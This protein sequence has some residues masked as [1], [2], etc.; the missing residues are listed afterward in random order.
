MEQLWHQ[1]DSLREGDLTMIDSINHRAEKFIKYLAINVF[2]MLSEDIFNELSNYN[3]KRNFTALCQFFES[4]H[5]QPKKKKKC[6]EFEH[7]L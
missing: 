7:N 1:E 2:H 3:Y 4:F 6:L 5:F